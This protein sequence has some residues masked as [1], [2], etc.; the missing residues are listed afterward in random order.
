[1]VSRPRRS[2]EFELLRRTS[3]GSIPASDHDPDYDLPPRKGYA[4]RRHW[5]AQ[6]GAKLHF[7]RQITPLSAICASWCRSMGKRRPMQR[8]QLCCYIIASCAGLLLLS[9]LFAALI[10]PSYTNLPP[11][12]K[13]LRDACLE[14]SIPGRGNIHNEK[15]LVA[16]ALHDP[17]GSLLR[18]DWGKS[19][20]GLVELL[21]PDNVH[22][23]VYE[24]DA[25]PTANEA[26]EQLKSKLNC[27]SRS[28]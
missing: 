3:S 22:L 19:V 28:S 4:P 16:A 23:S 24:N 13:S 26:L 5:F 18:G 20:M 21:G 11:H 27:Q 14:S 12:Y 15:V 6:L 25:D 10:L 17:G 2:E 9:V 1:M 8:S 7:R